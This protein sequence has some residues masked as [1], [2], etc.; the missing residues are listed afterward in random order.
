MKP[1]TADGMNE[2]GL[3]ANLL[4][5]V[6]SNYGSVDENKRKL[7]ITLWAQYVLDNFADVNDAVEQLQNEPFQIIAPSLPNGSPA[8]LHLAISDST[9]E[10]AIFEYID[11]KLIIHHGKQYQVMT[12]SP[13]F[14]NQL[15]LNSYWI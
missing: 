6:E 2:K 15:A 11:G 8:Q 3:V 12:N 4:Y 5:L 7:S 10:S 1:G 14:D 9:G 13:K